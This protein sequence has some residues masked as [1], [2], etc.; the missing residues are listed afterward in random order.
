MGLVADLYK[1]LAGSWFWIVAGDNWETKGKLSNL[2]FEYAKK[3][4]TDYVEL[5]KKGM[6]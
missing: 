1:N 3:Q 6:E 5:V 2:S 4:A